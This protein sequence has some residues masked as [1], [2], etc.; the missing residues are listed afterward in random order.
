MSQPI[1][2]GAPAWI[3]LFT[4]NADA[5]ADFY[6]TV[7]GWEALPGDP[8]FGGY[9][10]LQLDGRAVGGLMPNDG[11]YDGPDTWTVYL[12]TTDIHETVRKVTAAG[13]SVQMEPM[14]VGDLCWSAAITDAAGAALGAFQPL[15]HRGFG[16]AGEAN[17]P[18]WF[19]TYSRDYPA[20]VA[21]YRDAF[22]WDVH[23]MSDSGDF[24]YSTL[25]EGYG[26]LAGIMDGTSILPEGVPSHWAFYVQVDNTDDT[27][28]RAVAA[29][30]TL[31]LGVD[32]SPFGRLAGL[33]DPNGVGFKVVQPPAR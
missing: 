26:A 18:A 1:T 21:F 11:S 29:G 12:A 2:A 17:A 19:E 6:R 7:F 32:D 24:R 33:T 10:I 31:V 27:V 3:E 25:G 4:R 15:T 16:V 23:P 28:E 9:R 8:A 14:Q 22:G 5:A 13:G 20:S 30:A